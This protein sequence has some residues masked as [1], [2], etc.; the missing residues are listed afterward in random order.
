MFG[1]LFL[2]IGID[3]RDKLA[4][5]YQKNMVVEMIPHIE[6]T[7]PQDN[8]NSGAHE[9]KQ[10]ET[11]SYRPQTDLRKIDPKFT[12]SQQQLKMPSPKI[13]FSEVNTVSEFQKTRYQNQFFRFPIPIPVKN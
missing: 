12:N 8:L 5:F 11:Y 13:K 3:D 4:T 6:G 9:V 2:K 10:R 7:K 1:L